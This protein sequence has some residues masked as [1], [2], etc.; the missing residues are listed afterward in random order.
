MQKIHSTPYDIVIIGAGVSGTAL[1]YVLS[2]YSNMKRVAVVE[3]YSKPAQVAS[4]SSNNSQTLH[5]GDIETNYDLKK[6]KIIKPRAE[7]TL[8]FIEKL[9]SKN[10]I[11]R[12]MPKMVLGVGEDE[13]QILKA[14]VKEFKPLF[15]DIQLLDR[16]GISKI[17]P[18][19]VEGRSQREQIVA[20]YNKNGY[21]VN[22]E[23]LSEA[24]LAEAKK[25][26][27]EVDLFCGE[28]VL[29]I[30]KTQAGYTV[31]T[32]EQIFCAYS[33]GV[34]AG[35]YSLVLARSIGLGCDLSVLPT[36]GYFYHGPKILNGKVYMMQQPG[37]PMAAVHGDHDIALGGKTRFGPRAGVIF[38]LELG[39]LKTFND[40]LRSAGFPQVFKAY[41][42]I[43]RDWNLSKFMIRQNIYG[44]P[45]I[46]KR[47][48]IKE[49]NRIVP[50]LKAHDIQ[51]ARG[52]GGVRPQVINIKNESLE[53]GIGKVY[54][55]KAIFNMTPSPGASI[56]LYNAYEDG[57]KLVEML[58]KKYSFDEKRF[59]KELI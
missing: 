51:V 27:T 49:I 16:D 47:L 13:V 26:K 14:R 4:R 20:L 3:K 2:K 35:V 15:R 40:F 41:M 46:G 53:F 28:E 39:K 8:K 12:R 21:A 11:L 25:S 22:Y 17:E 57:K 45:L 31:R 50:S 37:L 36:V 43:L 7:M 44:L 19:L 52:T 55:D 38:W 5:T 18:S 9:Q 23:K 56:A 10:S 34:D 24:F 58:G 30:N 42:C 33:L 6:A 32:A 48:F 29:E 59:K 54:G 1:A